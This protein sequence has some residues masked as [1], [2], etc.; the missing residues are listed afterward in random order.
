MEQYNLISKNERIATHNN[1]LRMLRQYI[2]RQQTTHSA[3]LVTNFYKMA[4][5]H[6]QRN[7]FTPRSL[8]NSCV[9]GRSALKLCRLPSRTHGLLQL[10]NFTA[11][12]QR[13]HRERAGRRMRVGGKIRNF[14][15]ISRRI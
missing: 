8:G 11:K 13:G 6:S 14:Q 10:V 9:P 4:V 7:Y 1:L 5:P 12:F 2:Y 3:I 15:Q